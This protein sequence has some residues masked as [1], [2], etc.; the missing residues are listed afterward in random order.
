MGNVEWNQRFGRR[1]LVKLGFLHRVGSH[2]YILIPDPAA[3]QLQLSS[4]GESRYRELEA[5]TR[6]LG[7]VR[8]D[9]TVSYVWA[10]GTADLN[11]YDQFYGNFRN[12]LVRANENSYLPTDVRHRVIVRGNFGIP[13]QW[14]F[15][16]V[17]ELAVG[18]PY[19]AVDEYQDFVG[20]R[21]Q[22]RAAPVSADARLPVVAS[23]AIQ[24]VS[25]PCRDQ[26]LQRVRLIRR[27]RCPEQH[28]LARLRH[29]RTTQSSDRL[30]SFSDQ[31]DS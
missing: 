15:A 7:G 29:G 2:E 25:L 24:E 19:S 17:L 4:T 5:T 16:P 20:T 31:L 23:V 3:G 12:P 10:R 6:Y 28:H 30:G 18:F 22:R 11:N 14:D 9:F 1:L 21:N 27:P 13:G 26:G 8:R